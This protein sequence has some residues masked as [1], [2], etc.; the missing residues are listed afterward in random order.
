LLIL[1]PV[2]VLAAFGLVSLRQ[3]KRLA[4]QEA[5]E[6]AQAIA[7]QFRPQLWRALTNAEA[8]AGSSKPI[9]FQVDNAGQLLFPPLVA[10]PPVPAP[11]NEAALS[12]EQAHFWEQARTAEAKHNDDASAAKAYEGFLS[13]APPEDFAVSAAYALGLLMSRQQ[14]T[15]RAAG[16]FQRVL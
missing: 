1:L 16:M 8:S 13:L 7:D 9:R 15:G 10:P 5:A 4:Q 12:S 11:L 6:R 3:D 2:T 14:E